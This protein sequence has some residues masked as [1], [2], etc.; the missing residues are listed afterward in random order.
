[1]LSLV[2]QLLVAFF[3]LCVDWNANC[4]FSEGAIRNYQMGSSLGDCVGW[5]C[6][7]LYCGGEHL[8]HLKVSLFTFST[9]FSVCGIKSYAYQV[10]VY[11]KVR[12]PF[13][14]S[15]EVH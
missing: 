2:S 10:N 15:A 5:D 6:T 14:R 4:V 7:Y 13:Y 12:E 9:I 11:V 1:M 8:A 3:Q